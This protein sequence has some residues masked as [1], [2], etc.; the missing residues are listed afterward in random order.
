ML[1]L[2]CVL[3]VYTYRDLWPLATYT[4][5]PKDLEREGNILWA[6]I[7]VLWVVTVF[8]PLFVPRRYVPADPKVS[9]LLHP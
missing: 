2:L 6:K 8:I 4:M 3:V 7:F 9:R 5:Y 1:V